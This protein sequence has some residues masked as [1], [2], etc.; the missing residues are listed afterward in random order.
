MCNFFESLHIIL[1]LH[2][3][4]PSML[5]HLL[6]HMLNG[7]IVNMRR[8]RFSVLHTWTVQHVFQHNIQFML[9]EIRNC[10]GL[11]RFQGLIIM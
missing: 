11:T 2:R 5:R 7:N 6:N 10:I 4:Q 8:R 9:T 1:F 3:C